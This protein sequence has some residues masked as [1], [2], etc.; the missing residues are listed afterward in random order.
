M[1]QIRTLKAIDATVGRAA[2]LIAR[3]VPLS[4]SKREPPASILVIRPGGIGDAVLLIPTLAALMKTYPSAHVTILAERRNAAIFAFCPGIKNIF[5]YDVFSEFRS[6]LLARYDLVIDT[7][8][9]HR[10]SAVVARLCRPK[11]LIGFAANE[12]MRLLTHAVRYSHDDYEAASFLRLLEPLGISA[13]EPEIPFLT[14]PQNAVARACERL[15]PLV[16]N[17]FVVIFPGASIPERR[18]GAKRFHAL[19]ERAR[20]VGYAVVVVGGKDDKEQGDEIISDDVGLNLAGATS[21][22]ETAVVLK[23]GQLLVS[24]DSG[25]LHLAVGLGLPTVSLFGPG[26]AMKWAPKGDNHVVINKNLSCSPCTTF[27]TTPPCP[28][29]ARCMTEIGVDEVADKMIARLLAERA[30]EPKS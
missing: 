4:P 1:N 26:R 8:Q 14:I 29:N 11:T 7:E 5:R 27:G 10:F 21:L 3:C 28:I 16:G 17:P 20:A 30:G 22:I 6:A 24:G 15:E 12:R 25:I 19:A 23:K 18:W 13:C 2:V 9:W